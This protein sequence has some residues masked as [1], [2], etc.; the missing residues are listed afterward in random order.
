MCDSYSLILP[1][2]LIASLLPATDLKNFAVSNRTI[3]KVSERQL[4]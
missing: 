1:L 4:L 3:V 2:D